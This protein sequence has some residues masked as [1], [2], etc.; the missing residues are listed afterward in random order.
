[1]SLLQKSIFSVS[2]RA[3]SPTKLAGIRAFGRLYDYPACTVS[4]DSSAPKFT[5]L[6]SGTRIKSLHRSD[7]PCHCGLNHASMPDRCGSGSHAQCSSRIQDDYCHHGISRDIY[8]LM[9]HQKF[10]M[11]PSTS[12]LPS[13][14]LHNKY[15]S[16]SNIFSLFA[17]CQFPVQQPQQQIRLEV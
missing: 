14:L 10:G 4:V 16:I 11:F 13:T 12:T 1:M 15:P 9:P 5:S 17:H 2:G 3:V 8:Q 7:S 6:H